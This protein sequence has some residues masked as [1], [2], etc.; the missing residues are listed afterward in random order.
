M[1]LPLD[2][3]NSTITNNHAMNFCVVVDCGPLPDPVNGVVQLTTTTLGS[4]AAYDCNPGFQVQG[5]TPRICLETAEWSGD[6]PICIRES[7]HYLLMGWIYD[8]V[9][10]LVGWLW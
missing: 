7:M 4:A 2:N 5:D 1:L 9:S 10:N 6:A 3:G 8:S